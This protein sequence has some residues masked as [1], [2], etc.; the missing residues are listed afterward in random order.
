LRRTEEARKQIILD[1][2]STASSYIGCVKLAI[3][4]FH[5]L[6]KRKLYSEDDVSGLGDLIERIPTVGVRVLAWCELALRFFLRDDIKRCQDIVSQKVRPI[7]ETDAI[8][9]TEAL[10]AITAAAAPALYCGHSTSAK[11]LLDKLP[12]SY[13]DGG[14]G[15]VCRF[16]VTRQLP[17]EAY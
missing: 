15:R 7:L 11:Q 1:S 3:R 16:L 8:R 13:R 10:W 14:Y 9:D 12:E 4:A 2:R 17:T 6:I 5:G